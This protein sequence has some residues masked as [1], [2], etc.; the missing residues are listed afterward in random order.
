[1]PSLAHP[2]RPTSRASV[3]GKWQMWQM[4]DESLHA[5]VQTPRKLATLGAPG[6]GCQAGDVSTPFLELRFPEEQIGRAG[7][8]VSHSCRR[9]CSE[10]QL[11]PCVSP[12]LHSR[13][14]RRVLAL[15]WFCT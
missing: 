2:E 5:H 10:R 11:S 1:M 12:T 4:L 6:G 8:R 9:L 7:R 3:I 13:P 14:G 15:P